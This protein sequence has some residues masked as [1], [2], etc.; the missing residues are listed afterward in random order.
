MGIISSD[1]VKFKDNIEPKISILKQNCNDLCD[2]IKDNLIET[3]DFRNGISQ[4]YNSSNISVVLNKVDQ[5]NDIYSRIHTSI[6]EDLNI[7]ILDSETIVSL[8]KELEDINK[9]IDEQ[10]S[11]IYSNYDDSDESKRKTS[12]AQS[13][14]SSLNNDFNTK[15][16]KVKNMFNSL[17]TRDSELSFVSDFSSDGFEADINDLQYGTFELKEFT[18]SEGKKIQY[19]I[20]VPDYG[21]EV[22]KLP[23]MLYMH[24]GRGRGTV[25]DG[26]INHGLTNKI[27]KK[28]LTP[29]GIVIM[30]Y[31]VNFEGDNIENTLKELTDYVVSEYEADEDR[32]SISGHS[33]GGITTYRMINKYPDYFSCA[34][35][36]S[37]AADVTNAFSN[38]KVWSFNG[39]LENEPGSRTSYLYSRNN[40]NN[41]NKIGGQAYMTL[42]KTGHSGTNKITYGDEYL[43]PDGE[44]INPIEWAFKQ[45]KS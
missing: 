31:I 22:K 26:W 7:M 25:K 37:G 44:M 8:V 34:I 4:F 21:K 41:I 11:I 32:I 43:S 36:I 27:S 12:S 30:P 35:P 10:K 23:V 18:S 3:R 17:K 38:M 1:L 16:E 5:V 24:G 2:K 13:M 6:N 9:K 42:L 15:H 39:S 28:E 33:Y 45:V 29:S 40:V 19:Y 14:I 20:Y